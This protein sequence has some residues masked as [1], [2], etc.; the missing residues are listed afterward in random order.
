L[1]NQRRWGSIAGVVRNLG[2]DAVCER[3]K[4]KNS[5]ISR[6]DPSFPLTDRQNGEVF[7]PMPICFSIL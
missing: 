3:L 6:T 4:A 5:Q 1:L 2:I 7:L